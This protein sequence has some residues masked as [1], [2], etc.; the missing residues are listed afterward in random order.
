MKQ[1]FILLRLGL[2]IERVKD[3]DFSDFTLFTNKEWESI[4]A[5]AERQ[6]ISA[7]V[8]DGINQLVTSVDKVLVCGVDVEWWKSF[9]LQWAGSMLYIEQKN[10]HQ[11]TVMN[12]LADVF[13][14]NMIKM[15]VIKGQANGLMYPV[16]F[17][18]SP[19]DIDCY[20]FGDYK[21]GNEIARILGA[22]VDESWYKHSVIQFQ[23]E[24]IEN[25]LYFALTREGGMSKN[26]QKV[27]EQT[28]NTYGC[29]TFPDS[30]VYL[31]PAQWN[32]M[33]L[34]YHACGHFIKEGLRLKQVLD[35]AMFLKND[36]EKVDWKE[37]YSFCDTFHFR[38]F[39]DAI[40]CICVEYL[41]VQITNPA[42]MV[43]SSVAD[44]ILHS[45]LYD[46]DYIYS[47]GE[48]RWGGRWH[49]V[50]S[51]FKYRWKYEE[52]YQQ[53]IW[54]QLWWY[55]TGFLFHTEKA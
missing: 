53:S 44:K 45:V 51:L 31:P 43:N 47:A 32:A 5:I 26:L 20:L 23:N 29:E 50:K 14:Q 25:H 28:L 30:C 18:R 19:G 13:S 2:G 11:V 42:I 40:T 9:L 3:I 37:Y 34:T 36:Q 22:K 35:W 41:G 27:L 15:M 54:K 52:I 12:H 49:L 4:R 17:H 21:M 24:T 46:D 33:F 55:F 48:S 38:I 10:S 16:P 39:A 7:I 6:G 8:L 1:L